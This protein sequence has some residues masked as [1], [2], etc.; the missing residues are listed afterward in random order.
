[1]LKNFGTLSMM[2][3]LTVQGAKISKTTDQVLA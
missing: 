1:M 3:L 2:G